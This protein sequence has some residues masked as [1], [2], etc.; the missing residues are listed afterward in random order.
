MWYSHVDVLYTKYNLFR[1]WYKGCHVEN[2]L[3]EWHLI[4]N[5]TP[6]VIAPYCSVL[7]GG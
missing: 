6:T 7:V 2:T 4:V 1:G 3:A 5:R